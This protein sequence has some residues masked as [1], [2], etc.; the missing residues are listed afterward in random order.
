MIHR[1]EI[2]KAIYFRLFDW[3]V[4]KINIS[5]QLTPLE[6]KKVKTI[7]VLDIYVCQ[8]CLMFIFHG[9]F[10]EPSSSCSLG[11]MAWQ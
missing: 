11:C 7:G 5:L 8:P 9:A 6:Q 1:W 3:I 4:S 10:V 2:A